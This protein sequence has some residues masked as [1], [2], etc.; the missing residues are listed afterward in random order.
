MRCGHL[1]GS[2]P[3]GKIVW[4]CGF[5]NPRA[6]S[7]WAMMLPICGWSQPS[8]RATVVPAPSMPL[9]HSAPTL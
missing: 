8:M 7:Y 1:F 6:L 4:I 9:V 2:G 3:D 5:G